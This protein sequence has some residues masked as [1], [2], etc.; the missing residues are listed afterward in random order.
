MTKSCDSGWLF[1]V[2]PTHIAIFPGFALLNSSQLLCV[3]LSHPNP[4]ANILIHIRQMFGWIWIQTEIFFEKV[5]LKNKSAEYKKYAKL[6]SMQRVNGIASENGDCKIILE[7]NLMIRC[8]E[9]N[10]H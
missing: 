8:E 6:P 1:R 7:I 2:N 3:E 10:A 4:F 5:N 9:I